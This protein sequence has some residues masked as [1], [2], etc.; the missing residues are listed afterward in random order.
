MRSYAYS[1]ASIAGST[2]YATALNPSAWWLL[3]AAV[4]LWRAIRS[5]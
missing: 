3:V 5:T 2:Y 4:L 1:A